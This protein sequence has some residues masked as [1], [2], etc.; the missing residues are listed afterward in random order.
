[1]SSVFRQCCLIMVQML[2]MPPHLLLNHQNPPRKVSCLSGTV[3]HIG[4]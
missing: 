3:W 4:R 1:M 2:P